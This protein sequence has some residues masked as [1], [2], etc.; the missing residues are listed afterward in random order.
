MLD[1]R[2][3]ENTGTA[4]HVIE[5]ATEVFFVWE[6]I[7]LVRQGSSAGLNYATYMRIEE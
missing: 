2:M 6:H 4:D 7:R 5:D 1:Y 3:E